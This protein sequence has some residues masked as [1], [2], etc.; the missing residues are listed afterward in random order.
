MRSG[1]R[2]SRTSV[3]AV[4]AVGLALSVA[5]CGSS[6]HSSTGSPNTTTGSADYIERADIKL[7]GT[8]G[9]SGSGLQTAVQVG[10]QLPTSLSVTVPLA[11]AP[12]KG[13]TF[14][15]TNCDSPQC[16]ETETFI[17]QATTAAGWKLRVINY[18]TANPATLVAAM[19]QAL[20][21]HPAAVGVSG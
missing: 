20:Q 7:N 17:R 3:V 4:A 9:N 13:K 16:P 18:Q 10:E 6:S 12:P 8:P 14:V 11:S 15:W 21:Y 19:T 1:R 5:A 2:S